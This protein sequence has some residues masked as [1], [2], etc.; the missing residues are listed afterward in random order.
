MS[1][2]KEFN[3]LCWVNQTTFPEDLEKGLISLGSPPDLAQEISFAYKSSTDRN[4][5]RFYEEHAYATGNA[6]WQKHLSRFITNRMAQY[7]L[8][9]NQDAK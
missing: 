3:A 8:D 5:M 4:I 1:T 6:E 2:E 7:L 9:Q